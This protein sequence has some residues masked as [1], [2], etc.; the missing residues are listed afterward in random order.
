MG[1]LLVPK[2]GME[3]TLIS[4]APQERTEKNEIQRSFIRAT[5]NHQL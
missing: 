3:I 2:E 1:Y 5:L 4:K